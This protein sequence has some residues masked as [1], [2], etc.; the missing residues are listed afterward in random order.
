MSLKVKNLSRITIKLLDTICNI[1]SD[2]KYKL[3]LIIEDA[4]NVSLIIYF[5]KNIIVLLSINIRYCLC[6]KS[7]YILFIFININL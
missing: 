4:S 2:L 3:F 1:K 5:F 6:N 7:N